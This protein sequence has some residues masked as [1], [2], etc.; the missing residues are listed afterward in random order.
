MGP[1]SATTPAVG[2]GVVNLHYSCAFLYACLLSQACM[3]LCFEFQ[4]GP[5]TVG[6]A[7]RKF[8]DVQ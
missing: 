6:G 1:P 2:V 7:C 4:V 5:C 3:Q 8:T